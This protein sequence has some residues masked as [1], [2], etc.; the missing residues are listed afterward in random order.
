MI[1][2]ALFPARIRAGFRL[3]AQSENVTEKHLVP[4]LVPKGRLAA[5]LCDPSNPIEVSFDRGRKHRFNL[6][7]SAGKTSC[8]GGVLP[9][10][11]QEDPRCFRQFQKPDAQQHGSVQGLSEHATLS[12]SDRLRATHSARPQGQSP[13]NRRLRAGQQPAASATLPGTTPAMPA[14]NTTLKRRQLMLIEASDLKGFKIAATDGSIGSVSDFL[15]DDESWTLRW[16]V[17][18]TGTW[19]SGRKVLLPVSVLGHPDTAAR[20]FPVRLSLAAV[21]ASPEIDTHQPVSRQHEERIYGYYNMSPYWGNGFYLGGYG[22]W[23]G[24]L[25]EAHYADARRR[26]DELSVRLHQKDDLHLRSI[27]AVTGY[28]LQ[29]TDGSIGHV[30]GFLVDDTDWT[31]HFLTVDTRNWWPGKHVL[32]SPRSAREVLWSESLVY[33]DID[34]QTVMDSP[35]YD[36]AVPVDAA[37]ETRMASHYIPDMADSSA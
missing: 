5:P 29:A 32:I 12:K 10:A 20:S 22:G 25:S 15:F 2:L 31:I 35:A 18:D 17:V 36:P 26:Q 37:F 34:R 28:N 16:I 3:T 23:S 1:F 30:E 8:A 24:G 21:R 6:Y 19:L 27:N 33:L 13:E 11:R 9:S 4:N 14:L 7:Q